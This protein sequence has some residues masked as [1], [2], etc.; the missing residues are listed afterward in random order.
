MEQAV[1]NRRLAVERSEVPMTTGIGKAVGGGQSP[2][3]TLQTV[4]ITAQRLLDFKNCHYALSH[5]HFRHY[6]FAADDDFGAVYLSHS[7]IF[8]D[9]FR[10][11]APA[12][13]RI[14]RQGIAR[15]STCA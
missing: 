12:H 15:T 3:R 11:D 7:D 10:A 14:G 5:T 4:N 9:C 13:R 6:F 8:Y 2:H 1:G